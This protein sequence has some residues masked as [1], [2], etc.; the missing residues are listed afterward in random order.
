MDMFGGGVG[1]GVTAGIICAL[2]QMKAKSD[3]Q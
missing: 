1:D 3:T 2:T